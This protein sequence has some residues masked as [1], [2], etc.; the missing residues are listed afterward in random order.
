M[1]KLVKFITFG[2]KVNQ[3]ETEVLRE[4][5]S[6]IGYI[7]AKTGETPQLAVINSCAVTAEG[8][9]KMRQTLRR[10]KKDYPEITVLLMGC[11]SQAFPESAKD[12]PA[13][14]I[15]GNTNVLD[16][17]EAIKEYNGSRIIRVNAHEKGEEFNTPSICGMYGR[18]RAY[19]KIQDGC[20]RFCTYCIIPYARG[21]VRSKRV[22]DIMREAETLAEAGYK[23]IVLT[24]INLTA[25]GK[26]TGE[27]FADAVSAA[28]A[29]EGIER[30]RLGS[31][32]PDH[33]TDELLD[34]L[35]AI[36]KLCPHFH[37][38]LQSG[39]DATLKRM[40]RH[41]DFAFYKD[42]VERIRQR[43]TNTAFTT[44][45][46]VGFAGESEE[47]FET[48]LNNV[49]SVGFSKV[50]VFP[51]SIRQG[52]YAEKLS[53]HIPQSVKE[54]RSKIMIEAT[55]KCR[56][57]FLKTQL[58]EVYPVLFEQGKRGFFEGSTPNNCRVKVQSNENLCGKII[59]VKITEMKDGVLLGDIVN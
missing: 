26:D 48:S 49:V 47:E 5:L 16:A 3:Y 41:Y 8:E 23:E 10:I 21:R 33:M 39:C 12:L 22:K 56:D 4:K 25:F 38:S 45:V 29:P 19:I 50:H 9:R 51:Y 15:L 17:V 46:M 37:L 31:L 28:A 57:E 13:D 24:G 34:K 44:D 7:S 32:E 40:N 59:N 42:L 2:C 27:S 54:S 6:E 36:P 52:T 53:G 20:D 1:M 14:I 55:E 58:D 18:T 43:F 35:S 11:V 30:V